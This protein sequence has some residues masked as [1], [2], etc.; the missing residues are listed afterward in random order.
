MLEP[1][2]VLLHNPSISFED[3]Q[4]EA[5]ET[6]NHKVNVYIYLLTM[7]LLWYSWVQD[8][9]V[10]VAVFLCLQDWWKWQ[11]ASI[12]G[13]EDYTAPENNR[14][15]TINISCGTK[16]NGIKPCL[17]AYN[18][19][20]HISTVWHLRDFWV[21]KWFIKMIVFS[22]HVVSICTIYRMCK[23]TNIYKRR[24]LW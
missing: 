6:T 18:F 15:K 21:F 7:L 20:N 22:Q 12:L 24:L 23:Q 16:P 10:F 9:D 11:T 3:K 17:L 14:E 8:C 2:G 19:S 5:D 4:R 1:V 13:C